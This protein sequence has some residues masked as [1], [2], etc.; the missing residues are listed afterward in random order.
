ML[1]IP[2]S[3]RRCAAEIEGWLDLGC[4]EKALEKLGPLLATAAARPAGLYLRARALVEL[5]QHAKALADI[6]EIRPF[7][8]DP[9]WLDLAEAWCLKRTDDLDGAAQCMERLI[10]RSHR[11]AIGHFN[12]GCYLAL[13]GQRDRAIEEITLACGLEDQYRQAAATEPDLELLRGD[14]RFEQLI[15]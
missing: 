3:L 12:L 11:S 10:A 9:D 7:D 15:P 4:P 14:P 8:P 13:L 5:G 1:S 2:E 6:A